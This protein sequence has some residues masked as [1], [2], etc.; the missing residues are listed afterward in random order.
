METFGSKIINFY[1]NLDFKGN[2]PD[3]ISLMNPFRNNPEIIRIISE[4]YEKFFNDNNLRYIILGINP[5]RF[6]A[7][8]T[9]IN[10]TDTIRLFQHC[11][12]KIN[13]YET[14]EL[15]SEFIY[16]MIE[17]YGGVKKFYSKFY[18][19]AV[20]PLGFVSISSSGREKNYNYYDSKKLIDSVYDFIVESIENQLSF[21]INKKVCICLGTGK[22][23]KFLSELNLKYGYFQ[24][25]MPLEHPRFIMQYR[26][27]EMQNYIDKYIDSL[28]QL[29]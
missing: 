10:F 15:S 19:S 17:Q 6:G 24:K 22:N 20:C 21:G 23:F 26:R 9:G 13:S 3:G 4:F 16:E 18:M 29:L 7:G 8:T 27:K 2:L 25:I 14:R 1:K 28:S 11:G 12:I 5:G